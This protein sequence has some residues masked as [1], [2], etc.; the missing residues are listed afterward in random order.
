MRQ[1]IFIICS[2]VKLPC[3]MTNDS[4]ADVRVLVEWI[5]TR[6]G[7]IKCFMQLETNDIRSL[8]FT[9]KDYVKSN[10]A[11]NTG[12]W[13]L[14]DVWWCEMNF[15]ESWCELHELWMKSTSVYQSASNLFSLE[16]GLYGKRTWFKMFHFVLNIAQGKQ[17]WMEQKMQ[18]LTQQQESAQIG[19]IYV[20]YNAGDGISQTPGVLVRLV[21]DWPEMRVEGF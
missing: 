8:I 15:D 21:V 14:D 9:I 17:L 1:M 3:N 5:P 19:Q 18:K 20:Q 4:R 12:C 7:E 2:S 13:G 10:K 6:Y 11:M 16:H